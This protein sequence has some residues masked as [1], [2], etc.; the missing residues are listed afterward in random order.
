MNDTSLER[1]K[2]HG[3][4][5]DVTAPKFWKLPNSYICAKKIVTVFVLMAQKQHNITN[6][7]KYSRSVSNKTNTFPY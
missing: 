1:F 4:E 6:M 3:M 2:I 7:T 5:S